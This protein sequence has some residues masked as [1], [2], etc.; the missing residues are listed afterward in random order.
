MSWLIDG[1]QRVITLARTMNGDEGI[2]VVF[3]P[4]QEE[5]RLANAATRK[6]ANW[7]RVSELWD[8]DL[9]RQLRRNLDGSRHADRREARFEALRRVLDYEIPVVRMV[10]HTFNDAVRAFTRIN[11]LGVRLKKEDIESAQVAARHSGFVA[12]EVTPFLERLRQ[13]GFTRLNIMHLFRACAFVAK[14][15]GRN[16]TPLH[17]LERREVL[18][19]WKGTVRNLVSASWKW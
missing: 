6:D 8:D 14:P 7:I 9:Y 18:S 16:R 11:T 13:Q 17:E 1:Q 19:A 10:D 3:H 12:D 2:D 4:E 15:D 5:F